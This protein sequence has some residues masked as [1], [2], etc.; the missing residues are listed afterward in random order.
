MH[1]TNQI[2]AHLPYLRRFA[3]ALTGSQAAGDTYA[4]AAL[5]AV[6]VEPE[7]LPR[8]L[9]LNTALY[10][11]L[12]TIWGSVPANRRHHAPVL[13]DATPD[14]GHSVEQLTPL[15]RVCFLLHTMEGFSSD[16]VAKLVDRPVAEVRRLIDAAEKEIAAQL[17]ADVLIIEDETIIS[18]DLEALVEDLGHRVVG[19]ART[20]TEAMTVARQTKPGLIMADIQLADGSSG[21]DAVSDI[22]AGTEVPVVFITAYP[23]RLLTG[24]RPEPSFLIT[25]PFQHEVVKAVISQALFF[26]QRARL[27]RKSG[28]VLGSVSA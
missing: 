1:N 26:D 14:E 2:A 5:E 9:D 17:H 27:G 16:I 6:S 8:D 7:A 25:K 13:A 20:R 18:M 15:P 4:A 22:L 28:P 21:L 3:R 23:Q 24:D 12:L 10:K 11:V 19:V